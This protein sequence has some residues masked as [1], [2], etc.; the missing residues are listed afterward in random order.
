MPGALLVSVRFHDGRYHG[1]SEW[2]PSPARLFQALIA[3][4]ARGETL[5]PEDSDALVWLER[6][7][8]PAIVAPAARPG[9]AFATYVPNNDLDAVGGDPR[10]V[11]EIRA[12]KLIKPLLFD[13]LIPL[14]YGWQFEQG[15]E[16]A[17]TVCTIAE[18]LYQLGRGVDMAWAWGEVIEAAKLE[19][20]LREHGGAIYRRAHSGDGQLLLCPQTGSLERLKRRFDENG[21]RFSLVQSGRQVQQLFSQARKPRFAAVL[22]KSPARRFLFELR[23]AAD[24]SSFSP[25]PL[26]QA[27]QLVE[28]VRDRATQR[29]RKA[30]PKLDAATVERVLI[31]RDAKEID[32]AARIRIVP[33]P[34]IGSPHVVRAIRRMLIE[35]PPNCPLSAEDINWAFSALDLNVDQE[36]GEVLGEGKPV[37]VGADDESMLRHYGVD[38]R[39]AGH[40]VWR[41]VTPAA[42]P[43]RAARRRT[44]PRRLQ[45]E[46]AAGRTNR[47]AQFQEA[48]PGLERSEEESRAVVAVTQ[49]LRHAGITARPEAIRVQRE[50]FDGR[51]ARVEFFAPGTRFAKERLWHVEIAFAEPQ[52]GPLVVGDGRYLGLGVMAPVQDDWRDALVF[53][54][55]EAT[56][57]AV[58]DGPGLVRAV[59]RALMALERDVLGK[60]TKLFSGHDPDGT[61][62]RS[63]RQEHIFLAADDNDGDG[64]IDRLVVM[65]PWACDR[66]LSADR[67]MRKAFDEVV[68]RLGI[69]R[70]GRLGAITLGPP[71]ELVSQ[72]P[73]IGPARVWESRT[74]YRA[75]RHAGRR[76]DPAEALVRDLVSECIRRSLPRP[77]VD[78]LE[79]L[80]VP[81]GGGLMAQARL[82]FAVA[83]QG[84]LLLGRDSHKG[85]GVFAI[86]E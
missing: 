19:E 18:R 21:K 35:V 42:L 84:P 70:A 2:P 46:L 80:A 1:R 67:Q 25:W 16:Y 76:K 27:T 32:K 37:L 69:V 36:T 83:V 63:G 66:S 74:G 73:L 49:A 30:L 20:C 47:F 60:V 6:L 39:S 8:P 28:T 34:S 86:K 59:R 50:P 58:A 33:L 45:E 11:A 17:K 79:F 40:R 68:S 53:A 71:F 23:D 44:D 85:G 14:L 43:E 5:S 72:D 57:I 65:A 82:R 55:P 13:A 22:Y 78:I 77:Q 81:N 10:R 62:A 24:D 9:K 26:A 61:P 38:D 48:K 4:S 75:T 52:G 51:G 41:T 15:E 3:G 56:K 7:D 12:P 31:G 64:R 29:L 54:V